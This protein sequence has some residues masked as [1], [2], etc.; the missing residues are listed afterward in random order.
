MTTGWDEYWIEFYGD[1][2]GHYR[3]NGFLNPEYPVLSIGMVEDILQCY[4]KIIDLITAERP[5]FQYIAS[6]ILLQILGLL[7]A[8]VKY[9]QFE[10]KN[11]ENRIIQ[12]KL[13]LNENMQSPVSQEK[14]AGEIGMGYS[15]YRKKFKEYTGIS[16]TQYQI[17]LKITKAKELLIASA[18]TLKEIAY[19]LGFDS[20]DYFYRL[21]KKK[22]GSTPSEYREKNIR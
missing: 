7:F 19:S 16:P 8:A 11:I 12:A 4:L 9:Q 20:T 17:H 1:L 10:G 3:R 15:L 21:F 14:I 18:M 13:V 5:C 22:T 6:G 2:I